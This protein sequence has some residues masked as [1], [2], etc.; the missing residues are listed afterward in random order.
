MEP[1]RRQESVPL[2]REEDRTWNKWNGDSRQSDKGT[3]SRE[4]EIQCWMQFF[5]WRVR[6]FLWRQCYTSSSVTD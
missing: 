5:A 3:P 6:S 4:L 2:L 1:K